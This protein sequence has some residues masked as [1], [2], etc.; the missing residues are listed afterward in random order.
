MEKF[1]VLFCFLLPASVQLSA[2]VVPLQAN[3]H[4]RTIH[5]SGYDWTVRDTHEKQGPGPNYFSEKCVWV[6][7]QGRL[8]LLISKDDSSGQWRCSE[9]TSLRRFGFG[10]YEFEVTGAIDKLDKNIVLGLF[11][12]S[13]NDGFDE[14][15]IEFARW[16]NDRYPNLNY[17]VWPAEKPF[18]NYSYTREF[19]LAGVESVHR[20]EW[21][22]DSVIFSS[23]NG[24][25]AQ[26][27]SI[28]AKNTCTSPPNSISRLEMPVHLNF[29]LFEGR[30]PENQQ[31]VELIIGSFRFVPG[32]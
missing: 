14:L 32:K 24:I 29:W 21:S 30:P 9:I 7:E 19:T 26:D 17:T 12:Y 31:K 1:F 15:D 8:H 16:G 13:G 27:H 18:K 11:N 22:K 10:T 28:I 6:D 4:E 2:Q 5:F 25:H 20:F 23:Y 3:R